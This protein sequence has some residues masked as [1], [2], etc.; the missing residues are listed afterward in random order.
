MYFYVS[1]H[2]NVFFI[3]CQSN[4]KVQAAKNPSLLKMEKRGAGRKKGEPALRLHNIG[5][6]ESDFSRVV[7]DRET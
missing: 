5:S 7:S 2:Y 4:R 6:R 3:N 1:I